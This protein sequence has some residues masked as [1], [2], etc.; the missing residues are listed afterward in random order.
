MVVQDIDVPVR[1]EHSTVIHPLYADQLWVTIYCRIIS[2][3]IFFVPSTR[4]ACFR[5]VT[6]DMI[7]TYKQDIHAPKHYFS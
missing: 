3:M 4:R 6:I 2:P 1:A 7:S 5:L